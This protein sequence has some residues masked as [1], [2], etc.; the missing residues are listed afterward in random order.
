MPSPSEWELIDDGSW[1]GVRKW[2]KASGEDHGTVTVKYEGYDVPLI[3]EDNKRAQS[4]AHDRRSEMWHAAKIPASVLL[5][6]RI[7]HGLD[8]FNP[9]HAEGVRRLLNSSEY[10]HLRRVP[11]QI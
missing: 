6:W 9:N 5:K 3:L 8:I 10:R 7:E 4:E 2:M 11:F 1:N